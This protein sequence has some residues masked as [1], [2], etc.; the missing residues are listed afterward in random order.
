MVLRFVLV[1]DPDMGIPVRKTTQ[2]YEPG[3]HTMKRPSMRLGLRLR[4]PVSL[5][6]VS[7]LLLLFFD[8]VAT[9]RFFWYLGAGKGAKE[10]KA[11]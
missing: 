10:E 6:E 1:P 9:L 3:R 5:S 11:C 4:S 8:F 2:S 7:S